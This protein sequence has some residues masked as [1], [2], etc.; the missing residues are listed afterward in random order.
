MAAGRFQMVRWRCAHLLA[1]HESNLDGVTDQWQITALAPTRP[2][3]ADG[4][5][6]CPVLGAHR[7]RVV[8]LSAR[9]VATWR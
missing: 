4:T 9:G 3:T 7:R 5:S 8:V 2:E 6:N 1:P